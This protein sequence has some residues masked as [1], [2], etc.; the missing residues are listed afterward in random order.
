ML[1]IRS[2]EVLRFLT[3][4]CGEGS[5]RVF[6]LGNIIASIPKKF[7]PDASCANICMDYLQKGGYVSIKYKD[8]QNYCVTPLPKAWELFESEQDKKAQDVKLIKISVLGY[9]LVFI[10][11]F[12]GSFLAIII[13]GLIV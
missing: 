12:L 10:F 8:A 3:K 9:I 6:E 1:D 11:A 7:K 13:Y 2:K 4:E 5:Y